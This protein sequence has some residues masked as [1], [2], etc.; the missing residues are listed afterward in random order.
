MVSSVH[1]PT[2][3]ELKRCLQNAPHN[4]RIVTTPLFKGADNED[5]PFLVRM[6]SPSGGFVPNLDDYRDEEEATPSIVDYF[7]RRLGL[8]HSDVKI[9]GPTGPVSV[10]PPSDPPPPDPGDVN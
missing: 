5:G 4:C 8:K 1:R 3:G 7:C 6:V 2:I 10:K 9:D